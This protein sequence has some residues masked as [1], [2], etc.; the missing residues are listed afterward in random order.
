MGTM[1][2][3]R[4]GQQA[5]G[6]RMGPIGSAIIVNDPSS[7]RPMTS[8]S[9]ANYQRPGTNTNRFDPMGQSNTPHVT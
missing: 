1:A 3:G 2:S 5:P 9:A 4:L 6:S 8:I 7:A